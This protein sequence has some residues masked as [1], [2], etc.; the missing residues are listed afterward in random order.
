MRTAQWS[1]R[2]YARQIYEVPIN[3]SIENNE[4]RHQL[5]A[6]YVLGIGFVAY[7]NDASP[8]GRE[9]WCQRPSTST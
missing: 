2:K 4:A 7:R 5:M 8:R 9:S 6:N 3:V 1:L